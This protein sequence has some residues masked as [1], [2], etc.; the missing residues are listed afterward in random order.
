MSP[1]TYND[2]KAFL[3][4]KRLFLLR[5][6]Q[7]SFV[8]SLFCLLLRFREKGVPT[9]KRKRKNEESEKEKKSKKKKAVEEK[10][11]PN[12]KARK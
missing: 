4:L 10:A 3:S 9:E 11:K 2:F 1:L 8:L 6:I 5:S 7:F 12:K